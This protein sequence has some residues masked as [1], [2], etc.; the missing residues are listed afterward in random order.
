MEGSHHAHAAA[1]MHCC[2]PPTV[3][4]EP[5]FHRQSMR[6][7]TNKSVTRAIKRE[8]AELRLVYPHVQ[9]TSESVEQINSLKVSNKSSPY[10]HTG[11][12]VATLV[13]FSSDIIR[14]LY[15]YVVPVAAETKE[16]GP[17]PWA[18]AAIV[19]VE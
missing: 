1:V 18:T 7:P 9:R 5:E 17:A 8:R 3:G 14:P 2:C 10:L 19:V 6:R 16:G 15:I 4:Y 13:V 12:P 11:W